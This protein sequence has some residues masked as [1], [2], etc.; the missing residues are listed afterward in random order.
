MAR[1]A[2]FDEIVDRTLQDR[3]LS[4]GERKAVKEWVE[5]TGVSPRR[6]ALL[7]NRVFLAAAEVGK[8]TENARVLEWLEGRV[9]ALAAAAAGLQRDP[10]QAE[11]LFSPGD[12]CRNRL[13]GLLG[14]T[15]RRVEICVF[16]ITDDI[17]AR[18]IRQAH[19]RGVEIRILTDR[20]KAWDEGS[21]VD[22]LEAQGIAVARDTSDK[23]MHHKFALFDG[24]TLV[25][26]SYNWTRCAAVA[27][28][29]NLLLTGDPR[30]V[31]AFSQQFE[32]LWKRYG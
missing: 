4:R 18:A 21:D 3:R 11:A 5:G 14:E 32:S 25:T 26:G 20:V 9:G 19:R 2:E 16:S 27:N 31:G 8:G 17:L 10:P 13:V 22:H 24:E 29:E 12:Q 6:L 7:R 15:R 30:L 28:N 1:L 23:H